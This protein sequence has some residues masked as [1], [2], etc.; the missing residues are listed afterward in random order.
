MRFLPPRSDGE[1]PSVGVIVVAAG[2]G[3]R[4]GHA[5]PKAFVPVSGRAILAHALE[6][7]FGMS[8]PAQVIVVAPE[9]WL[10]EA[11][12]LGAET[13]G[14]AGAYLSVVA[15]SHTRQGSVAAGLAALRPEVRTV[16][17]HDAARAFTPSALFDAVVAGVRETGAGVIPGLPVSDTIKRTDGVRA[18]ATVDRSELVAVQTPQGFPRDLLDAAYAAAAAEFTDDAAV[19][20][21]AGHAVRIV[22]GDAL[23][24]KITTAWDL[25]RAESLAPQPVVR[26]FRSGVGIDVHA[27]DSDSPLWLGGL[28]W[29]GEVGL[30]GHSDGD[31]VSHAI[32]DALLSAAG[33]GDVGSNFGTADPRFA[34]A[35]GDVFIAATVAIVT[36]ARFEVGNVAVQVV[37]NHPKVGRRRAQLETHLSA[38]VGAPVSVAAT[39]SDGL[40]FTGV[41]EGVAVIATCLLQRT[42]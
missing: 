41:G 2:S 25:R 30:A 39:T 16:L 42:R 36:A 9:E 35:H 4:L 3:T 12:R 8:E 26:E 29:P 1:D 34:D 28:H 33:C 38:L 10:D 17:V 32:C 21:A 19:F 31:A 18:I 20:S 6:S 5:D 40:G 23:A 11:K 27:Y 13:A 24:F 37:A 15:G 7:V 22:D 14:A